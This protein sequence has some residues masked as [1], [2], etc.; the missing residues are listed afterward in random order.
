[1]FHND[2]FVRSPREARIAERAERLSRLFA[3]RAAEH[4]RDA[5]FPFENFE[6]LKSE[7]YLKLTAPAEYGGEE[8][9]LYEM[10]LSQE[11]LARGDGST[12]LAVGWHVGI[13]LHLRTVRT[14]PPSLYERLCRD[15][16]NHGDMINS[17]A[18]E[19]ATGSPSRG[20]KPQTTAVKTDGGWILTGRKTYSTL[21]PIL[22]RFT[23]TAGIADTDATGEFLVEKSDRVRIEETWD[24]IGMRATGSHDVILDGVFVPDDR[25]IRGPGESKNAKAPDDG[26][27]WLLHIPA[28]YLGVAWAAR[29]FT[30]RFAASYR[31]NSLPGPIADLP[32][33][34]RLIGD[35][36]QELIVARTFLYSTAER[37]DRFPEIRAALKPELGTAKTLATNAALSIV[38][39]AMRIVGGSSLSRS[40]PLERYYRDVRAGLHNPP[41]EDAVTRMLAQRALNECRSDIENE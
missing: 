11:R 4:D 16:T 30:L 36:E 32:H 25:V 17:F 40:L 34:Q 31:P 15:V 27:G 24:T 41:M 9:T 39:Q 23:V 7:G 21:S 18:S 20:G 1:M 12:A 29:D 22:R 3:G 6:D 14:W 5:S 19:P 10:V 13:M 26:A 8:C 35:M 37:W 33:I 28:C 38:D 2:P